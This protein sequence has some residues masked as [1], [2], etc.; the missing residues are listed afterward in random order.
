MNL[1]VA[2]LH[3]QAQFSRDEVGT[4]K[5]TIANDPPT[6][7]LWNGKK[8]SSFSHSEIGYL[9]AEKRIVIW[10]SSSAVVSKQCG[11]DFKKTKL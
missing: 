6:N 9:V 8:E 3:N 2:C 1:I 7:L 5:P 4:M 11:K 10:K